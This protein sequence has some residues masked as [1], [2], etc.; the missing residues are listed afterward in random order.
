M[1][2]CVVNVSEGRDQALI[3]RLRQAGNRSLLDTHT[4]AD[5]HRTVLTLAGPG[6]TDAADAA[7]RV[8]TLAATSIDLES[9][10]GVHPRLGALDVVPFVP[11]GDTASSMADCRALAQAFGTWWAEAHQV[12]VFFYD[13]AAADGCPLP[14]VRREA[15]AAREPDIGPDRPHPHLGATAVGA[16]PPLVAVN[17][18]LETADVTVATRIAASVRSRD[19]GLAGVRALGFR[20]ESRGAAQVS[21]NLVALASTGLE[22]ACQAV[23]DRARSSGSDVV[24]V[25]IVG[26][27]P[28]AEYRRCSE[29]F[30][31]WA[32]LDATVTVE[33]RLAAALQGPSGPRPGS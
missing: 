7:R 25:E 20:L 26:L 5:H 33:H 11:L 6:V 2:E 10:D 9:H 24:E 12:P 27:I 17:C 14:D 23:R 4:D 29:E 8:A 13:E 18:V 3:E 19:G 15:F 30:R 31:S 32:G 22:S 21:M 16:R 28:D 1:I